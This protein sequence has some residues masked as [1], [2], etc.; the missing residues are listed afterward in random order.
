MHVSKWD[1]VE[2]IVTR[3]L[4]AAE[5]FNDYG[6]DFSYHGARTL[7][8]AC[9]E[10]HIFV[11]EL[12]EELSEL[13]DLDKSVPDF[14]RMTID[15]LANYIQS[16]HHK[17]TDKKLVL[18]KN[19]IERL[20]RENNTNYFQ[21]IKLKHT[22]EHLS[23]NLT[24]HMQQEEFLLFPYIKKMAKKGTLDTHIFRS[25]QEPI[26]AM[27]NDHD[28]E[29]KGFKTLLDITHHYATPASGDLAYKTTYAA[30]KELEHDM[31]IHMHLENNV[32]FPREIHLENELKKR[33]N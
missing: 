7:E 13:K 30:I 3:N 15:A 2:S 18:I 11:E 25:I 20:L 28:D 4:K 8:R 32:L 17:Y 31:R 14:G 16:T 29:R 9:I 26:M 23:T 33:S 1:T 22:F 21:L 6:I 12:L 10:G 5:I 19:N 24:I 27:Q